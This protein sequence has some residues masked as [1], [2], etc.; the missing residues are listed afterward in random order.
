LT[1]FDVEDSSGIDEEW[2]GSGDKIG[3]EVADS[4]LRD[5]KELVN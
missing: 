2:V 1:V 5:L 3:E 4:S